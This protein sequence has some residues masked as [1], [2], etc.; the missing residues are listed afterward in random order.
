MKWG[1]IATG[2]IAQAVT[3]D[4]LKVPDV[5]VLAVS[6]RDI[7]KAK[8]FAERF[9]IERAYGDYRDLLNDP[10][11]DDRLRRHATRA[12]PRGHARGTRRGQAR[13]V[14]E[15]HRAHGGA[16][17]GDDREGARSKKRFLMEAMWTRFNPLIRKVHEAVQNGEIGE[18]RMI[19]ADFGFAHTFDA[20]R[21]PVGQGCGRWLDPR[22]RR[23][24][25]RAHAPASRRANAHPRAR[26]HRTDRSGRRRRNLA[27]LRQRRARA[28]DLLARRE[29]GQQRGRSSAPRA[30]SRSSDALFNPTKVDHQRRRARDRGRRL[31]HQIREVEIWIA[32]GTPAAQRTCR[33]Q[34]TLEIMAHARRGTA[35]ARRQLRGH[36]QVDQRHVQH[37]DRERHDRSGRT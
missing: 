29:H 24:P 20:R 8:T 3:A 30:A 37:D 35:P 13:A 10:D 31:P 19:R 18:V 5:E 23:V 25:G 4:M 9:G 1:V 33:G 17:R 7:T 27:G 32:P 36:R 21:P 15:G 34:A 6:S 11:V 2:G 28:A 22:P 12:A 16:G 26:Q 14:R